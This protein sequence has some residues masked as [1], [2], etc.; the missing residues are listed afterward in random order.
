MI[1]QIRPSIHHLG[2]QIIWVNSEISKGRKH[3]NIELTDGVYNLFPD[4]TWSPEFTRYDSNFELDF[5]CQF[6]N[7]DKNKFIECEIPTQPYITYQF[8]TT[9]IYS[10][11]FRPEVKA[12]VLEEDWKNWIIQKYSNMGFQLVD[13]G[14]MKWSLEE[15]A[16]IMSKSS[17]HVGASSAFGVFSRCVGVDFTHIYYNCSLR[18]FYNLLPD[19]IVGYMSLFSKNGIRHFFRDEN[20]NLS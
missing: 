10:Q 16:Y 4:I 15:T 17:G 5:G 11:E 6:S 9:Q 7:F 14:G 2:D 18:E 19:H 12:Y 8:D 1:T 13:V 20:L 3:F